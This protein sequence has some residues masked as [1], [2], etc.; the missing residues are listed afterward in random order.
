MKIIVFGCGKVGATVISG[1]SGEG[2]DIV[3]IDK[4]Q[5]EVEKIT[6]VY[7]VMGLCGNGIDTDTLLEAGCDEAELF[8]AVT[9]SDELNMLGCFLARRMGAKHTIARLRNP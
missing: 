6:N 2:H 3:A 5:K 7:D 1:L 4:D 9:G 8:V